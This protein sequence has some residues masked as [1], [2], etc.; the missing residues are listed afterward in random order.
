MESTAS[1]VTEFWTPDTFRLAQWPVIT[2][3]LEMPLTLT[4]LWLQAIVWFSLMPEMVRVAPAGAVGVALGGVEGPGAG[5]G[6][7]PADGAA[8][9]EEM[10]GVLGMGEGITKPPCVARLMPKTASP[11]GIAIVPM[12]NKAAKIHHTRLREVDRGGVQGGGLPKLGGGGGGG[13]AGPS[14]YG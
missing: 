8:L 7:P 12:M 10:L 3:L 11:S 9:P 6:V 1:T 13:T 5:A 14:G 4:T 2:T